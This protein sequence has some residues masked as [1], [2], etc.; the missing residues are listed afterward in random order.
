MLVRLLGVRLTDLI[1][2]NYQ[3]NI[4]EDAAS[5]IN[6]YQAIDNIKNRFGSSVLFRARGLYKP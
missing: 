3:I 5:A 6:L 2:G 1:P 4:F